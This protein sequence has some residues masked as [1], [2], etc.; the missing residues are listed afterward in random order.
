VYRVWGAVLSDMV[1]GNRT[2]IKMK[3]KKIR[4]L[5]GVGRTRSTQT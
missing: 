5:E 2:K 1:E 4:D 3:G